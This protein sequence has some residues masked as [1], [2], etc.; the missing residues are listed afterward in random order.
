MSDNL[1]SLI[2]LNSDQVGAAHESAIHSDAP[3]RYRHFLQRRAFRKCTIHSDDTRR[4]G[5]LLQRR[6]FRKCV[7][8]NNLQSLIELNCDQVAAAFECTTVQLDDA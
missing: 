3:R 8:S 1:Q 5:D 6:A 4:Y 7:V 2:E